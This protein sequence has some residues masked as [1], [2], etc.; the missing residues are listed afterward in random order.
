[1][2]NAKAKNQTID[3]KRFTPPPPQVYGSSAV[4]LRFIFHKEAVRRPCHA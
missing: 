3:M 2:T 1:V 4:T